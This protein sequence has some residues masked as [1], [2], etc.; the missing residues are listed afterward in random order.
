M[1]CRERRV[2]PVSSGHRAALV[3]CSDHAPVD[4][5]GWDRSLGIIRFVGFGIISP[6]NPYSGKIVESILYI[7]YITYVYIFN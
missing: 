2:V 1:P 3:R 7:L 5:R 4:G 6:Q